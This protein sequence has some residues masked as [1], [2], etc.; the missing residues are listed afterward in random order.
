MYCHKCG[1]RLAP[2]SRF[3]QRCGARVADIEEDRPSPA[4]PEP[5]PPEAAKAPEAEQEAPSGA[6]EIPSGVEAEL[7]GAEPESPAPEPARRGAAQRAPQR[8]AR[9][10][11]R[12]NAA[13]IALAAVAARALILI[14]YILAM[15]SGVSPEWPGP[16]GTPAAGASEPPS[17]TAPAET[18]DIEESPEP[19][20]SA[21]ADGPFAMLSGYEFLF[22]DHLGGWET[23]L[24]I[25]ADGS[26]SGRYTAVSRGNPRPSLEL[27]ELP[28]GY[29]YTLAANFSGRFERVS[30]ADGGAL[31]LRIE[32]LEYA[33]PRDSWYLSEEDGTLYIYGTARGF[34]YVSEYELLL[35]GY[36]CSALS[37]SCRNWIAS[38]LELDRCPET[39]QTPALRNPNTEEA[40]AAIP[41]PAEEG[42]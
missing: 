24:R 40:F 28:A 37:G 10:R 12:R 30:G 4:P 6:Q 38:A 22:T 11:T 42:E 21:V 23:R 31:R 33:E 7:F 27:P 41:A 17:G 1:A 29:S 16:A 9:R 3:C 39:L 2:E 14:I 15:R 8:A 36:D 19:G 5:E 32:G 35:P 26:F 34:D 20:E 18:E 13:A 25:A